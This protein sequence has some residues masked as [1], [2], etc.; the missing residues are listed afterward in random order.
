MNQMNRSLRE[1]LQDVCKNVSPEQS[2]LNSFPSLK[3]N[4]GLPRIYQRSNPSINY[5]KKEFSQLDVVKKL[6]LEKTLLPR[7]KPNKNAKICLFTFMLSDGWGDFIA[8]KEIAKILANQYPIVQSIVCVPKGFSLSAP[9]MILVPY[10]KECPPE[11]F[12]KI[13]ISAMQ[14]ADL[15]LSCPTYVPNVEELKK[16]T[17]TRWL[18]VGQYGFIETNFFSPVNGNYCMGLHFLELGILI[19]ESKEKGDFRTLENKTLLY[20][21]FSTTTPQ[22]IDIERYRTFH[23]LHLAYLVSPIGGAIYMHAL[24]QFYRNDSRT[25]DICTPDIG[26]L[27]QYMNLQKGLFL[28]E[29][30]GIQEI[31][32]HYDGKIHRRELARSGKKVRFLS[33]S[34]SDNDFRKLM[35]LSEEFIAVR[36]DQS[37]SE[38]IS[39]NRLFFYDGAIHARYFIKDLIALAENKLSHNPG[40]L[41]LFRAMGQ[42]FAYQIPDETGEW[43]E[44][45]AFQERQPWEN[46]AN[47]IAISLH[48]E[49]TLA[50]FKQF[51]QMVAS[52]YSC[53]EILC[54][55]VAQ[56]L[57]HR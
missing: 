55:L 42:A 7:Y 47:R 6:V 53:N 36:G 13:A 1:V 50:G 10:D 11:S 27:I 57:S 17:K 25:I 23:R 44:E 29:N 9:N 5:V 20:A 32:I 56:E 40:A 51:N 30:Y 35:I 48:S 4:R 54:Q 8:H 52:E 49:Q 3:I 38:A 22:T 43:V 18:Q 14:N 28:I 19:R 46:I 21:L 26:W 41:S 31:E 12:S 33:G 39:A 2:L 34:L 16:M 15:V 37:F 45:T 24:F